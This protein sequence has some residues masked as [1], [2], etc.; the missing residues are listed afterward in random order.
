MNQY[1]T[2]FNGDFK[3]GDFESE[4][5]D[6]TFI[7]FPGG[8]VHARLRPRE[9]FKGASL[10]IK[11]RIRNSADLMTVLMMKEAW[12]SCGGKDVNLYL[13]YFPYSRQDRSTE[14]GDPFS[15][16][17][18]CEILK[19]QNFNSV[20]TLDA[21]SL[22]TETLMGRNFTNLLPYQSIQ[23][24]MYGLF[25]KRHLK[26]NGKITLVAPDA[27]AAKR[28]ENI[29]KSVGIGYYTK[30]K[31]ALALKTRDPYTGNITGYRV[32]DELSDQCILI[33]DLCDG[34]RT[35]IEFAKSLQNRPKF[36]ALFVTHGIFSKGIEVLEPHFDFIGTTDSFY[37][38]AE[39]SEKF[40]SEKL[41]IS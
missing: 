4:K 36:L 37:S 39:Y 15:L 23:D 8:E 3:D 13:P 2:F 17:V 9:S 30:T 31:V 19:S 34:G 35:F 28:V 5:I 32:L 18:F 10:D 16:R 7:N 21:H 1:K 11:A 29:A 27:G 24:F 38:A 25:L 33:D 40:K 22:V 26:D 41:I 6:F 12:H 14:P 20:S